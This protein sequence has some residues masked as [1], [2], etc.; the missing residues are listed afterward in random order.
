MTLR[1]TVPAPARL[2]AYVAALERGWSSSSVHD[3]S[4]KELAEIGVD[5][6]AFIA[7]LRRHEGSHMTLP[8]GTA[9]EWLPARVFWLWNHGFCGVINLRF[10]PGTLDLPPHVSGHIGYAV[11]PWRRGEGIATQALGLMLPIAW[12]LGLPRVLLT[13]DETNMASRRVIEA[14]GGVAAGMAPNPDSGGMKRL[15][16]LDTMA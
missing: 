9:Q 6:H 1:L 8:D 3:V 7:R 15:F 2:P 13:C 14:N 12:A 16:W 10:Q 4:G 5:A 11:V